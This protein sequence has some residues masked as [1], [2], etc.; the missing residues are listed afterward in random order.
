MKKIHELQEQYLKDYKDIPRDDNE[1]L[2][3]LINTLNLSDEYKDKVYDID[4]M[5][6]EQLA[7]TTY[8]II[9]YEEPVGKPRPRFKRIK[10][11]NQVYSGNEYYKKKAFKEILTKEELDQ[12]RHNLISTPCIIDYNVYLKTPK[13]FNKL[14]TLLAEIGAIRPL[15]KPDWDNIGKEYSDLFNELIWIDD[16]VVISATLNKFY[17][18]LPRIEITFHVANAFY[19]KYQLNLMKKKLPNR[20]FSYFQKGILKEG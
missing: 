8:T 10:G 18:I 19:N 15:N 17:S 11:K 16:I 12:F 3:Y 14:D 6:E 4:K 7:Y 9:L 1:R 13:A 20:T 5:M 2:H